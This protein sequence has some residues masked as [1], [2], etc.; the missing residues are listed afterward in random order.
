[1]SSL[2]DSRP[3]INH[4]VLPHPGQG[5]WELDLSLCQNEK[6][7]STL[8]QTFTPAPHTETVPCCIRLRHAQEVHCLTAALKLWTHS[9]AIVLE[10]DF[11]YPGYKRYVPSSYPEATLIFSSEIFQA[12]SLI[13]FLIISVVPV[14]LY[15]VNH[16]WEQNVKTAH[17]VFGVIFTITLWNTITFA[18]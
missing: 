8:C 7:V 4:L 10:G 17:T 13:F 15:W 3:S 9:S 16:I 11:V 1:M 14:L 2:L 5:K 6:C 18:V 12:S